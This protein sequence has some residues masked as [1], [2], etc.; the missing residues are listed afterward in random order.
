MIRA[1]PRIFA[2]FSYIDPFFPLTLTIQLVAIPSFAMFCHSMRNSNIFCAYIA[3]PGQDQERINNRIL[4]FF[5]CS[6][7][8]AT[9][10]TLVH[11][12]HPK[13]DNCRCKG[14]S[15]WGLSAGS[16]LMEACLMNPSKLRKH[17]VMQC[18]AV[19]K[20]FEQFLNAL[21]IFSLTPLSGWY[22]FPK[23]GMMILSSCI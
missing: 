2:Y 22:P 10:Q 23:M 3:P 12:V 18:L 8:H 7:V 15:H 13:W 1:Y 16:I 6:E 5:L 4:H 9:E 20:M 11:L 21:V 19:C 17:W 14:E